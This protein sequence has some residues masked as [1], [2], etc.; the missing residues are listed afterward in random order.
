[1]ATLTIPTI[2]IRVTAPAAPPGPPAPPPPNLEGF[3]AVS[4]AAEATITFGEFTATV[5]NV[6]GWGYYRDGMPYVCVAP[7]GTLTMTAK[8]PP[9]ETSGRIRHGFRVNPCVDPE[10]YPTVP[11]DYW[12]AKPLNN[13]AF[14]SEPPLPSDWRP[15]YTAGA[16]PAIPTT[17]E[18]N[19]IVFLGI[20]A[21]TT[22]NSSLYR[23]GFLTHQAW[24]HVRTDQAPAGAYSPP[25]FWPPHDK[26]RRPVRVPD[27]ATMLTWLPSLSTAGMTRPVTW[28]QVAVHLDRPAATR[29][30]TSQGDASGG[31]EVWTPRGWS[32]NPVSNYDPNPASIMEL[33]MMGLI[34]NNWS[35]GDKEACLRRL[36]QHGCQWF[37]A[38]M[39]DGF[40]WRPDGGH[41]LGVSVPA[42]L[43]AVATGQA[44]KLRPWL[45]LYGMGNNPGQFVAL[46]EAA[47][48]IIT[49][50]HDNIGLSYA[51]R[52][53][54]ISAVNGNELSTPGLGPDFFT[55]SSVTGLMVVRES[56]YAAVRCV[57]TAVATTVPSQP[58]RITV[59]SQPS[60]AF[61]PGD[62][63]HCVPA[64]TRL[65]GDPEWIEKGPY[66]A[67]DRF[68]TAAGVGYRKTAS[69][70]APVLF[71]SALGILPT[72]G[73]Y[74]TMQDYAERRAAGAYPAAENNYPAVWFSEQNNYLAGNAITDFENGWPTQMWANHYATVAPTQRSRWVAAPLGVTMLDHWLDFDAAGVLFAE[75]TG[76][77][78][79][80]AVSVGDPVGTV[81]DLGTRGGY[82]VAPA[83]DA[84]P[85][86]RETGG[87]KYLE[88]NGTTHRMHWF[89]NKMFVT[90]GWHIWLDVEE[91][92]PGGG[93]IWS[94]MATNGS[95]RA[96]AL[97]GF[98]SASQR[99]QAQYG[100][101]D[102]GQAVYASESGSGLAPRT[103]V[104][105]GFKRAS[106][107]FSQTSTELSLYNNGTPISTSPPFTGNMQNMGGGLDQ[108]WR[109]MVLGYYTH[110]FVNSQFAPMNL[111]GLAMYYNGHITSDDRAAI[112]TAMG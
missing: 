95:T 79:A 62:V 29:V 50:P 20:A 93:Q 40:P 91:R 48:S 27:V 100:N 8:T 12:H 15:G 60:P 75:R 83:D 9:V 17:L 51:S 102:T 94:T 3:T 77:L 36:L 67:L 108:I 44:A 4:P 33:A 64:E 16:L 101:P 25:A 74:P 72:Y 32:P 82:W 10:F 37:E 57:G 43:W 26:K 81:A 84:R 59:A 42:I 110:A 46:T 92:S 105:V 111:Y 99:Y 30:A 47:I 49:T 73:F 23:D 2:T 68:C 11:G 5:G 66:R 19:D 21:A 98:G 96:G 90:H 106:P 53:R 24:L 97:V 76:M 65:P 80:T 88:F 107:F 14:D 112:R 52:R 104:E 7:G 39:R 13:Q 87:K 63:I 55:N 38:I 1:M 70:A 103:I 41:F 61:A 86:L 89:G 45:E 69:P 58:F 54:T 28:A 31:Y 35:A 22:A 34:G 78:A 56:P 18:E 85:I 6:T 71:F 109:G